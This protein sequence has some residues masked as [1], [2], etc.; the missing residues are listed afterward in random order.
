METDAQ[1]AEAAAALRAE[2][3]NARSSMRS[4]LL[5]GARGGAPGGEVSAVLSDVYDRALATRWRWAT[6]DTDTRLALV[7]TGGWAR[8]EV[9]PYSDIDFIL[10]HRGDELTAK[11]VADRLLYPLW[12]AKVAVGHAVREPRAAAKLARGDLATA[13]AL[14]DVR[15]VAG[16]RSLTDELCAVTRSVIAPGGDANDFIAQLASEKKKRHDRF[17]DSLYL[18]E[19]NLK[20]GIGALRDLSTALWAAR[21]RWLLRS[22]P[23]PSHGESIALLRDQG[24][25]TRRQADVLAEARDFLLGLRAL[26]QLQGARRTDQL[27]FEIQEALAPA[28]F[29]DVRR[30]EGTGRP[31]VAPAVEALMRAYY[32]HARSVVQVAD[33]LLETARVPPRKKPRIRDIDQTFLTFNGELAVRDAKLLAERPGEMLRLFRV[34]V[35]E[36]APV[37]GHTRDLI[38]EMAPQ[39]ADKLRTDPAAARWFVDALCDPR[40]KT[41]PSQLEILNQ[42]GVI[43]AVM[44]E[45]A[46]V[47]CRVQHDLYHVYTVDQHQLYAVA[48]LKRIA[49]GELAAEQPVATEAYQRV[50]RPASLYLGTLLHD[51]GKPMGKGHAEKGA[52]IAQTVGARLGLAAQDVATAEFLVRQHLTMSHLSQRRDLSDPEVVSRFADRVGD[53]ERL[54]QLYLLTLVDTAMTA[55]N[56]LTAWK[57]ELLRDLYLRARTYLASRG[58]SSPGVAGDVDAAERRAKVVGLVM[59]G[60]D[61]AIDRGAAEAMVA[62]VDERFFSQLTP[63][64]A[65]RHVRLALATLARGAKVGIAVSHFPLKGHSE[66]AVVAPDTHGVLAAIAGALVA[67]RVDV[68]GAAAGHADAP[69]GPGGASGG[70]ALDLFYVR[71]LVGAAIPEKDARWPRFE[72]DLS[73]LI[74]AGAPA[75]SDVSAL[76]TRRRPAS[77]LPPRVTPAVATEIR[78]DNDESPSATI[79]EVFTRDRLGVLFAITQTLAD[80]GLD[81]LLSKIS[82]EGEKV[83]DVFYVTRDG[84]KVLEESEIS[85]VIA[86]LE[87]ALAGLE[88]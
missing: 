15:H 63:R 88:E 36:D 66:V 65:A 37:Y 17:G 82:T 45:W 53:E 55:P 61:V 40:D 21:A 70:L 60:D 57:S 76:I 67:H 80:S 48:M 14:V 25:L 46:P 23:L 10:L 85:D 56:N 5:G 27:T 83:A 87:E 29:P 33:R 78:F 73:E 72:A 69:S 71:D 54:A 20:Q 39:H 34:A 19:P 58:G 52:V 59:H 22:G 30:G 62:G 50:T 1:S 13:T 11:L 26:A 4:A 75:H 38:T 86:R 18:L 12:D 8:R 68:L 84:R 44:P 43:A 41:Q 47:M 51:I 6:R 74:G 77:G 64:Q 31:A 24:H 28:M 32:L 16:D 35:A 3:G 9:A 49:R 81:I 79:L 7:A 2:L 42:L